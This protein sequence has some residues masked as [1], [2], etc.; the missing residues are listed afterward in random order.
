MEIERILV[1]VDGSEQSIRAA[2]MA[3]NIAKKTGARLTFISIA[4]LS[5]IPS[6]I[7]EAQS[8]HGEE[9]AQ[10]ALGMAK[11]IADA[12]GVPSEVVLRKGHPAGQILRYAAEFKPSI[13]AI[14]SRGLTGAAGI[15]LGS[16]S[17]SV[18]KNTHY[19]VLIIK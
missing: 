15:L 12:D 10:L 19:P 14:G 8:P 6:L 13:I 7:G 16:V 1:A 17:T 18:S 2:T 11:R 9:H 3:V 5:D 4:E